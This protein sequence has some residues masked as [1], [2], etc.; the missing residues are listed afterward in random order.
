MPR[1]TFYHSGLGENYFSQKKEEEKL[2]DDSERI[3]KVQLSNQLSIYLALAIGKVL[4][5]IKRLLIIHEPILYAHFALLFR[6]A[7]RKTRALAFY[8]S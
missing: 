8:E 5:L 6:I 3:A 7:L 4:L 2:A 1:R